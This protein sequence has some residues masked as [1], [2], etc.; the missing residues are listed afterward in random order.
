MIELTFQQQAVAWGQAYEVLVKRGVLACL[1]EEGMIQRDRAGLE[2]WR[3]LKLLDVSRCLVNELQILDES[4][5]D[6]I[7]V[8]V[9]HLALTAYG[10][11]YTATRAYLKAVRSRFSKN[12]DALK[13]RALWCPLLL[14][15][16]STLELSARAETCEAFHREFALPGIVD[17]DWARKGQP[18]N[19]DFVLWL[20]AGDTK[21]QHVLVQ[22]YSYDMPPSIDDFREQGAHLDELSRHR[23]AID[24]RSVFA[25][26]AAEVS[27]ETFELSD[28]IK[29]YLAALTADNKPFHKLCQACSYAET[30]IALLQSR[31]ALTNVCHARA[32]AITPNGL[33]SLMAT[34]KPDG[35]E[36]PRRVLMSQLASAYRNTAKLSDGDDAGLDTLIERVFKGIVNKLPT[37]LKNGLKGLRAMPD[38]GQ[39]YVFEFEEKV[40]KFNNPTDQFTLDEAMELVEESPE[41]QGYFGGSVKDA[42]RPFM[43]GVLKGGRVSLRDVHAASIVAGM[44][45]SK[46]GK[47]N[48]VALEGNPGIGKTTALRVHLG[49]QGSDNG[50]LFLYVSPRVVINRDVTESMARDKGQPTGILTVTT[51]APLIA[52]AE[53]WHKAQVELG[54]DTPRHIDGAVVVDGVENLKK[55]IGSMLV[56]NPEQEKEIDSNHAATRLRKDTLSE[57]EDMVKDRSLIG[58]LKGMAST[59]RELLREN[60][61]VNRL[62]LTA[63][64]QGFRERENS[65]TTID[66]LSSLF[67]NKA[68]TAAGVSERKQ[69]AKRMPTIVVM[70]D[71]LAGDG[72]GARFVHTIATWLHNEFI[73]CFENEV[74]PFTVTLVVADASL[75]NEVVLDRYLNAGERTPDKVL[76]SRSAGLVPFR[77]AATRIKIGAGKRDTLHVMTNSF[78]ASE[79]HLHYRVQLTAVKLEMSTKEKSLGELQ[80]PREAIRAAAGE[81]VLDGAMRQI[82]NALKSDARQ[83]IYFAQDKLFL[84]ALRQALTDGGVHGLHRDNVQILD[85]SIPGYRRRELVEPKTR[86]TIKVFLMTSSGARG[87]SF[88]LTDWIIAS[89]PRFNVE[90]SLMEIAQLI[91]RGRGMYED[92]NGVKQSG[93]RVPRHLVM[94]V[95]D[96]VISERDLDK[97]QWLRQS[98]DLMTLLVMLRSTVYTRITGDAGLKQPLALVPVGAVGTEE[99]ISLMSQHVAEFVKEA[100]IYKAAKADR[101]LTALVM[102][103][104]ANVEEIFSR[105]RLNGVARRGA[106]GRSIVKADYAET[107][108]ET[109]AT[110]IG[111]LLTAAQEGVSIPDHIHFSGPV[112]VESWEGFEKQEV[113]AFEGHETQLNR[114]SR[115]LIGQLYEIDQTKQFPPTMRNPANSLLRLLQREQHDAA[116][117]FRTLKDLKSP[118]TWVAVPAGYYSFMYPEGQR[119]GEPF[120]LDDQVLWQEA[121]GR[122]LN[123]GSAVIPPLPKYDS[124]PWAAAIGQISPLRLDLVFDDRYFMASN[125][126]NLLNTLLL[127]KADF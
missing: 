43:Q 121:L 53:R 111:P 19:A 65:K 51:N 83:V 72:A 80:T 41:L 44:K 124:F 79:L 74:S 97:R 112:V 125:E 99:L 73:E 69:F 46:K 22:E 57:H 67:D 23:R 4:A 122:S 60:P 98:L 77:L 39:D 107:L 103:A 54:L 9:R 35:P 52:A 3:E 63:A 104:K 85:S 37:E 91:Y 55:P 17:Q 16:E 48:V 100:E 127:S 40:A 21:E 42:I 87:V 96:Y 10:V 75:G 45:C 94:L 92:E 118:N 15:G 34:F 56:L 28:D 58:V 81:A 18:A 108:M 36:E 49:N 1:I 27:G 119:D 70:V 101:E 89:V 109:A 11:G 2:R 26:V 93:D 106:D 123:A 13:V 88:P 30:T 20:S 102:R 116:N 5:R 68:S 84:R 71:E 117:E 38:A 29:N 24:S 33:E 32:L 115:A 113:F 90:S 6:I 76:V 61:A 50:F 64:L 66:A 105:A 59:S 25:R 78:P 31:G 126:L 14:P 62:V 86:D 8:A 114:A 110:A 7:K 82:V 120:R 47:L 95:D 12:P